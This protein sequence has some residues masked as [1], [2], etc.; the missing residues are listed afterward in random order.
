MPVLPTLDISPIGIAVLAALALTSV[1]ATAI[2]IYKVL[3]FFR[4]GV[5]RTEQARRVLALWLSG[6]GAGALAGAE[7][8]RSVS[9]RVLYALMAGLRVRFDDRAY[10]QALAVQ[11]AQEE[12][13]TLS[14]YMRGIEAVVQAAPMLGL[15]GTVIGMIE[16]FGRLAE[17]TGAVDPAVLAGG[18]W[19]ALITTAVGLSIAIVFYF[20]AIWLEGRITREREVLESLM[21]SVLNGRIT[22][23]PARR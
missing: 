10:A 15:L 13:A 3:Q 8:R 1:A 20:A 4:L 5:G 17:S 22:A 12:L 9:L 14:R 11:V 23:P 6:D 18:I 21:A 2:L 7:T 16:A 19:T